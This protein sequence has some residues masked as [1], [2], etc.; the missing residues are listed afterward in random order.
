M[1]EMK[2]VGLYDAVINYGVL[3]TEGVTFRT[4]VS[5]SNEA[6]AV[7]KLSKLP[8]GVM[9][10]NYAAVNL[11]QDELAEIILAHA[12]KYDTFEVKWSHRFAGLKQDEEGVTVC[13]VTPQGEKFFK[14]DYVIGCDGG[15]SS[16][17]RSLCIPFEGYTFQVSILTLNLTQDYR[18]VATNVKYDFRKYGY[19]IANM[20]V[21]EEDWAVI[22]QITPEIWRIAYGE[23]A[24]LSEAEIIA[25]QPAK[26]ERLLP[27]P[28]PLKYELVSANPYWAHQ[29]TA[30]TY[31]EGRVVLCGDA[32]HVSS[33]ESN[34]VNIS[35]I[36]LL[37]D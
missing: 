19:G 31:R 27:G 7:L 22:G 1:N 24:H 36:I 17:R 34:V 6:L 23:P 28:R 15:G 5:K 33:P 9:K 35:R 32:A 14:A 10:D 2:K 37:A 20:I 3:N 21:D 26:Y 13:T 30:K 18:F 11:G 8:K 25:R 16:V 29:R 12:M 4:P